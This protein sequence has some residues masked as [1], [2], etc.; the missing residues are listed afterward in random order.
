MN[1]DP[2]LEP[3]WRA[4][5][6][7]ELE[8]PEWELLQDQLLAERQHG[9]VVLP[10]A[11]AVFA[12]FDHT[13]FDQVRVVIVGQDPYHGPGQAMGLAFSVPADV[14][15]PPSLRNILRELESDVGI[16]AHGHGDLRPW[17]DRGVLLLNTSLTVRAHEAGSHARLGWE[18]I[19]DAAIR[20]LGQ[21][22]E[23]IAFVL[24]GRHAQ[25]KASLIDPSRHLVLTAP[26]PSPLSARTGFFGSKPF[27]SVNRYLESRGEEPIDWSL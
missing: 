6:A 3:G 9:N 18:R 11:S 15:V 22:R 25:A 4:A 13:P 24:W 19:T 16:D 17:A 5:L 12:A 27:S 1:A 21:R 10:P 14:R 23:G 20:E 7:H 26:H 8:S 2:Q